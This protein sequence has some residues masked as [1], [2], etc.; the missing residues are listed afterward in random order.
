M[1]GFPASG[2]SISLTEFSQNQQQPPARSS[3]AEKG[4]FDI[5]L[6]QKP[7]LSMRY[8]E[9]SLPHPAVQNMLLAAQAL[10]LSS[11][12][13]TFVLLREYDIK[14]LLSVPDEIDLSAM[15]Y[16]GYPAES[17]G[18]PRRRPLSEISHLNSW[19]SPY[20]ADELNQDG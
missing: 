1:C 7:S 10:G 8:G 6:A 9:C 18:K 2:P 11:L 4:V 16:L 5:R 13:T 20:N 14:Q 12:L 15:I 3:W 17:L 19:G